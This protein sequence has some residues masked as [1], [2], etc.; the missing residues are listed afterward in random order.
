[1]WKKNVQPAKG[2]KLWNLWNLDLNEIIDKYDDEA[3]L[4]IP[5]VCERGGSWDDQ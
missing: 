3:K 1:M 4:S 5:Q 2:N